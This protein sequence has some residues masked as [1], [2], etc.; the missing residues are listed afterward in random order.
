MEE[1][2]DEKP[3]LLLDLFALV[4]TRVRYSPPACLSSLFHTRFVLNDFRLFPK[5][6]GLKGQRFTTMKDIHKKCW[7]LTMFN[8]LSLEVLG[9]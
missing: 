9:Q 3:L 5:K 6:A 1:R 4:L 7:A 2:T 8:I